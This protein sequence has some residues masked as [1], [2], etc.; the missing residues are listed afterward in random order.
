MSLHHYAQ[1]KYLDCV[2]KE[3]LRLYPPVPFIGRQL[4]EETV[5]EGITFP[6]GTFIHI[7]IN[8]LHRDPA[9]FPDPDRFDPERFTPENSAHRHPFAY[10]PFSASQR[11]C[12]GE[13]SRVAS[14]SDWFLIDSVLLGQ[15][16][17][18]LELKSV[19]SEIVLNFQLEPV[20][21]AEDVVF[22]SD[23]VLR[24]KHPIRIRFKQRV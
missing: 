6:V 2:I 19:I 22:K 8:A 11:N 1:M 15:K 7:L 5:L 10:I 18:M 14:S 13:S 20:T 21:R 3:T 12:I 17:A 23:L 4:N 24:S 9:H 16:F